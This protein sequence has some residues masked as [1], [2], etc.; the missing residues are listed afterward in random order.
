MCTY[1][2]PQEHL[3]NHWKEGKCTLVVQEIVKR[4]SAI[5]LRNNESKKSNVTFT[6]S[7]EEGLPYYDT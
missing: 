5:T 2:F 1:F 4:R 7:V 6:I 3:N